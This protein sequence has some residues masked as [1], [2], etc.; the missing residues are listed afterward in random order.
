ML[1]PLALLTAACSPHEGTPE[2]A[3]DKAAND[4]GLSEQRL[5]LSQGY[6]MLYKDASTI[7]EVDLMLYVKIESEHFDRVVTDVSHYGDELKKEL[8][9]KARDYP[10]VRID[11]T[12]LPEMETRKRAA[13]A[14]DKVIRFAPLGGHSRVEYERTMLIALSNGLNHES[15][16]CRVMAAEEPDAH[17]K[18]FLLASEKRYV[19]L[20]EQTMTLLNREYFKSDSKASKGS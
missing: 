1:L 3:N 15:H 8:E 18:A 14:K 16:L 11:L 20:Y 2:A 17:L 5:M 4:K 10:G 19:A 9:A 6:S 7:G 12:P 13:I